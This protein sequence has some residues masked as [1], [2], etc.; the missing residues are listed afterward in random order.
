M[1]SDIVIGRL[2]G[3]DYGNR[4]IGLALSDPERRIA[5]PMAT[6][7]AE[8]SIAA[9]AAAVA[10]WGAAQEAVG[11]VVGLPLN[12]DGS[13]G[14]QAGVSRQFADLLAKSAGLPV[15]LWDERLSTFQA[16]ELLEATGAR[17]HRR[18]QGR[19]AIAAMV[20]LQSYLDAQ[21]GSENE[22]AAD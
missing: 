9:N 10:Q 17:R 13:S 22:S 3:V 5:S 21:R 20:I 7:P 11:F 8:K 16:D 12:M 19:D 2:T 4:R 18:Q 6:L 14:P 1:S 15:H